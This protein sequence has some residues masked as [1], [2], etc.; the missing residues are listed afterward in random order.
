M[1]GQ[2]CLC[3]WL[4]FCNY[5]LNRCYLSQMK[6]HARRELGRRWQSTNRKGNY[7]YS[8][9]PDEMPPQ[10]SSQHRGSKHLPTRQDV[11]GYSCNNAPYHR[12][13]ESITDVS[14]LDSSLARGAHLRT[15]RRCLVTVASSNSGDFLLQPPGASSV[16]VT[17][18]T[19]SLAN[20]TSQYTSAVLTEMSLMSHSFACEFCDYKTN[21]KRHFDSHIRTH[22]ISSKSF[23]CPDCPYI[24]MQLS[25]LKAHCRKHTGER[26]YECHICHKG[27]TQHI[28]LHKHLKVH[29]ASESDTRTCSHCGVL[30]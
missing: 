8:H 7:I 1:R 13:Y 27:F 5:T 24:A 16:P 22:T 20:N 29:P 15:D 9:Q 26:P 18:S 19:T 6:D 2:I 23:P 30:V 3:C 25:N 14:L 12:P 11:Y 4:A 17:N 21:I 28:S 10:S